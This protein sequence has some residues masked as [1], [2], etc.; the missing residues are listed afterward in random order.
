MADGTEESVLTLYNLAVF[1]A[2]RHQNVFRTEF[3]YLPDAIQCDIY[4]QL[5][6]AGEYD[7]L[8]DE[9]LDLE[10]F[11]KALRAGDR[12]VKLYYPFQEL[13]DKG[14]NLPKEISQEFCQRIKI[15]LHEKEN[16]AKHYGTL[17]SIGWLIGGFLTETGWH[18]AAEDIFEACLSLCDIR[19]TDDCAIAL[20]CFTRLVYVRTAYCKFTEAKHSFD[21]AMELVQKLR[22]RGQKVNTAVLYGEKCALLFALSEYEQA[23]QNSIRALEEITQGL[24]EKAVIDIVRQASKACVVKR[25]FKKAETL[26]KQAME[27]A[28][29]YFGEEHPKFADTL[30]DYGFYLLNVDSIH[31]S[32][33]VYKTALQ[34]RQKVFGKNNV[35][36]ATAHE[37]LA[38]ALYVHEYSTGKFDEAKYQAECSISIVTGLFPQ[39]HLLLASS[40]RVKALILEEIAIDCYDKEKESKILQEA[41]DLHLSSLDLA[42]KAFGES[43]V[44][45]AKHYGNLGRLYQSMRRYKE[46]EEMHKRAI[47]IKERILGSED[48]EV[49]LSLGHLASL[50]NYDMERYDKA[51]ELYIRSIAI[52]RKLF[53]DG[54]SGLEYDYRGLINL[55]DS[56]G[57]FEDSDK[58]KAI[59]IEWKAIRE[60]VSQN[61]VMD[62]DTLGD[63]RPTHQFIESFLSELD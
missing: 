53:G 6:H 11:A 4:R 30:V 8:A 17:L 55:Y 22:N 44:Q 7:S 56:L 27:L 9:L 37:D 49:A 16:V 46:A 32:V 48:Y 24:P 58:Y 18:L 59:L 42:R 40:K 43:N 50:Y 15:S 23:Y 54:Y 51:E 62:V 63:P 26:I 28:R 20:R 29:L 41:Q 21:D 19:K 52:G 60:R 13:I 61:N 57:D 33:Q 12:R 35:H 2:V 47:E 39:D 14:Y 25:K 45:T 1:K 34:I 10:A 3:R 5:F 38:Y 36:V 31:M